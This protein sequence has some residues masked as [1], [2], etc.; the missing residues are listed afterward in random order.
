[1]LQ[2]DIPGSAPSDVFILQRDSD[3]DNTG[4]FNRFTVIAPG[5]RWAR[6]LG[7]DVAARLGKALD[8]LLDVA[9]RLEAGF[10]RVGRYIPQHV[11]CNGVA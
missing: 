5:A 11:G 8:P 1:M 7:R 9:E 10:D 2:Y 4:Q 3:Q 6:S